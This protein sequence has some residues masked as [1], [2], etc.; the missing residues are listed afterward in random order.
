MPGRLPLTTAQR[1]LTTA[2]QPG[3]QDRRPVPP[4]NLIRVRNHGF[5]HFRRHLCLGVSRRRRLAIGIP[6]GSGS[7]RDPDGA[8][9]TDRWQNDR[10]VGGLGKERRGRRDSRSSQE[11]NAFVARGPG[12]SDKAGDRIRTDDIHVGNVTAVG[13]KLQSTKDL[14]RPASH[15]ALFL[16]FAGDETAQRRRRVLETRSR[17]RSPRD[18]PRRYAEDPTRELGFSVLWRNAVSRFITAALDRNPGWAFAPKSGT[19][20]VHLRAEAPRLGIT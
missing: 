7:R 1:A 11:L 2:A 16:P 6:A 13:S 4:E 10:G 17:S 3:G 12:R 18:C 5:G 20:R 9:S 19:H 15:L 14:R 8:F